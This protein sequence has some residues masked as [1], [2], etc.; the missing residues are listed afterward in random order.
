MT[1]GKSSQTNSKIIYPSF[2]DFME[3]VVIPAKERNP[4]HERLDGQPKGSKG[5]TNTFGTFKH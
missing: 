4:D 1:S 2:V 3:D 5:N